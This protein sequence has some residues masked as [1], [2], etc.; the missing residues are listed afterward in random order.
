MNTTR[1]TKLSSIAVYPETK[2]K[3]KFLALAAGVTMINYT[4]D[5][6]SK[7]WDE[8]KD[9]LKLEKIPT[10]LKTDINK[11]LDSLR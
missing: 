8:K 9:K 3:L 6:V 10:S 1:K 7:L 4:N 2:I 11:L 5:I